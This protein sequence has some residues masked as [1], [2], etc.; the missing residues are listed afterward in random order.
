MTEKIKLEIFS[1]LATTYEINFLPLT[2]EGESPLMHS[3][4]DFSEGG[5]TGWLQ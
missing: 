5:S 2:V 1:P 3:D 4:L